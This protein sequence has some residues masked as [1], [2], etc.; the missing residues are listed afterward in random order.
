MEE[1]I[2][3]AFLNVEVIGPHVAE[4]HYDLVG[5]NGEIILPQAWETVIEGDWA[6]TMHMWPMSEPASVLR[7]PRPPPRPPGPPL[8]RPP[9]PPPPGPPGPPL[10][11]PPGPRLFYPRSRAAAG[12]VLD[13]RVGHQ[14]R[15]W[16]PRGKLGMFVLARVSGKRKKR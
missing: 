12:C 3:Q 7:P 6:V 8:S 1:L 14:I 4:G 9:G 10:S 13:P 5:P 2:R 15:G 11:R 16:Y